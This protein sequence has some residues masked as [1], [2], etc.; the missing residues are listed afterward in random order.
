L[1]LVAPVFA[2]TSIDTGV[3]ERKSIR[4]PQQN[5]GVSKSWLSSIN[6]WCEWRS[7]SDQNGPLFATDFG[8][9]NN[10]EA[11]PAIWAKHGPYEYD[12]TICAIK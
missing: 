12:G 8:N 1:N 6:P 9:T 2:P 4:G 3:C 7:G 10:L 5:N 11:D